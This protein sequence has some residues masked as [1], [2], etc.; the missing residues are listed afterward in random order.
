[1]AA[2][3]AAVRAMGAKVSPGI[4][5]IYTLIQ[6][7]NVFGLH[8]G[9]IYIYIYRERVVGDVI[10]L[11]SR[12]KIYSQSVSREPPIEGRVDDLDRN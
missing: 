9:I 5:K 10:V 11:F 12:P 2:R 7:W 8:F 1:M 6:L 4:K 3:G